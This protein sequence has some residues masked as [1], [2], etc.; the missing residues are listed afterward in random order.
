MS[1]FSN[2]WQDGQEN[3]KI[4]DVFY[5][6]SFKY[7]SYNCVSYNCYKEYSVPTGSAAS[8]IKNYDN[9]IPTI[10]KKQKHTKRIYSK[11]NLLLGHPPRIAFLP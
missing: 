8:F 10:M 1:F 7:T 3:K 4:Y 9:I 2:V 11:H 6:Y 5:I